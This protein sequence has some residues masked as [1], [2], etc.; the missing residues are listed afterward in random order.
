MKKHVV[1]S[2]VILITH[3]VHLDGRV[4]VGDG[5][6]RHIV[7]CQAL[8]QHLLAAKCCPKSRKS[9]VILHRLTYTNN[10]RPLRQE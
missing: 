9:R 1:V 10:G 2:G 7:P 8:T 3:D 5:E 6:Y 4:V